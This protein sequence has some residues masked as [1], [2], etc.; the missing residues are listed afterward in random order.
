MQDKVLIVGDTHVSSFEKLPKK[1]IKLI[2]EAD[3]VIH[4]GDYISID[5]LY[6]FIK[7][8]GPRFRGVYGNAD[9]L[10]IR[11]Q[12]L[13]KDVI[14]ISKKRIGITHPAT[15]GTYENTKKKVLIEFRN[16]DLDAIVYGHTH[17]PQIENMNGVL[18]IN[19]GKGYLEEHYY[20]APTSVAV[21]EIG[22][23]IIAN[24]KIID[25]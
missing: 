15:G 13:A 11:A 21:V 4:V 9:S 12:T 17:E 19:P 23:E 6:G 14:E 7:I 18:I 24:I 25:Y 1:M 2:K 22:K 20:G 5:V 16:Y 8:K 3:W 10:Q